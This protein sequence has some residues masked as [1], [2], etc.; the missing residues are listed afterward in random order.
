MLKPLYDRVL[1]KRDEAEDVSKG[2]IVIPDKAKEPMTRGEVLAVGAGRQN[3]DGTLTPCTLKPGNVVMFG[4][5][6]GTEV[7][8]GDEEYVILNESEILAI[9]SP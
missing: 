4:K 9:L 7:K 5:Y 3:D 8:D 1:V 2:G 6:A